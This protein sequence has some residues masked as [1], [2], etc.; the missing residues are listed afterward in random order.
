MHDNPAPP[1]T[2]IDN[3]D[4]DESLS[5]HSD[6]PSFQQIFEKRLSR[7]SMMKGSIG[8]AMLG[9]FSTSS[10]SALA[11]AGSSSRHSPLI[12]FEAISV[13]AADGVSLPKGYTHQ[14]ILPWG[15]PISGNLP[16]FDPM[17]NSGSDQAHQMGSHHD[18][19]HFFPIEGQ[20]LIRVVQRMDCW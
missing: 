7:R 6:N 11:S 9:F 13:S 18:G 3:H 15:Q 12:G 4:G 14:V 19:M 1:Q 10:Y 17:T 5:N 16:A 8:T 2:H 20:D